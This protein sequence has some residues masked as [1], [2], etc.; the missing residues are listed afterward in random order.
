[1]RKD[2]GQIVVCVCV[3]GG[4]GVGLNI[5]TADLNGTSRYSTPHTLTKNKIGVMNN[6]D[7]TSALS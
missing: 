2:S 4:S 7:T 3:R 5:F 1:M 6:E